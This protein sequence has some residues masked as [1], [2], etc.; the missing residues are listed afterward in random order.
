MR[1]K[2]PP[3][4]LRTPAGAAASCTA[5]TA[6]RGSWKRGSRWAGWCPS[7]GT[8]RTGAPAISAEQVKGLLGA[9]ASKVKVAEEAEE[10]DDA[11]QLCDCAF[12]L[13]YGNRV[14]LHNTAL[15]LKRGKCYGLIGPNGM[16]T[17]LKP[18]LLWAARELT[19]AFGAA[20]QARG[21]RP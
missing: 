4:P 15:K 8:S 21:S 16:P 6:T 9:C 3:K 10:Q 14:L 18:A 11:E 17:G 5:A 13:A 12:S 20:R 7:Q 19:I 1:R 2:P